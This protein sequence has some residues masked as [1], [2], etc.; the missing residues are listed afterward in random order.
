MTRYRIIYQNSNIEAPQGRFNIGRS[1]DCHLV[2]DDPSVSRLHATI[3]RE[4]DHLLLEDRGSRNGCTLN[5]KQVSG[6]VRL[7]DGDTIGIGHQRIRITAIKD[8]SRPATSTMGLASC[9][10][11]GA[12]STIG[13]EYCIQCGHSMSAAVDRPTDTVEIETPPSMP[14]IPMLDPGEETINSGDMLAGLA[15]KA[16]SKNKVDDALKLT[17]KL[18]ESMEGPRDSNRETPEAELEKVAVLLIDMAVRSNE[19]VRI[20]ELFVF[21]TTIRRLLPRKAVDKLYSVARS[22]GYRTS[23]ELHQYVS[24][25]SNLSTRFSPGEKFIFRRIEGLVSLCN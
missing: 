16:L 11:C 12:W 7:K 8:V 15:Q 22:V 14:V 3:I 18:M 1:L 13:D 9:P 10:A 5:G 2:L 21:F 6:I 4:N 25:L 17:R 24:C 23:S 19:P 20:A